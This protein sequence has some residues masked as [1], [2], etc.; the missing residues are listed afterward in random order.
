MLGLQN[1]AW[2]F[3]LW[4]AFLLYYFDQSIELFQQ[5]LSILHISLSSFSELHFPIVAF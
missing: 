2:S 4:M 1:M 3:S 5:V